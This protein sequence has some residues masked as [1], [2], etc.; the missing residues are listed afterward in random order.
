MLGIL[1]FLY[2][3][4]IGTSTKCWSI[5]ASFCVCKCWI[6]RIF[7]SI[8]HLQAGILN[9]IFFL[10]A[11]SAFF[12]HWVEFFGSIHNAPFDIKIFI[13]VFHVPNV[14]WQ[15]CRVFQFSFFETLSVWIKSALKSV[16][17]KSCVSCGGWIISRYFCSVNHWAHQ[18]IT[19]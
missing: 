3:N 10:I 1:K 17:C 13:F 15:C 11:Q 5:I 19:I 4:E 14:W 2:W 8:L 9:V 6:I 12:C 18:A 16:A 7:R